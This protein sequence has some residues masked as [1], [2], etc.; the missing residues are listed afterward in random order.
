MRERTHNGKKI[1]ER[2]DKGVTTDTW[3]LLFP[4]YSLRYLPH[5]FLDHCPLLINTEAEEMGKKI[6]RFHFEGWWVLKE[7]CEEEIRI[8]WEESSGSF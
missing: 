1:R 4:A 3:L 6:G 5:S 2:I 8:L 7:S